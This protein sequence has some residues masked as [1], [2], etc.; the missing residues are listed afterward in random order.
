MKYPNMTN[1]SI[2]LRAI[3]NGLW[4]IWLVYI[5]LQCSFQGKIHEL[6]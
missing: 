5:N 2:I 3:E 6:K 1:I 4:I